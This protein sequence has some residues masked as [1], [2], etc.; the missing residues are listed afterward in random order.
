M[1]ASGSDSKKSFSDGKQ[2]TEESGWPPENRYF[3]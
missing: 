3:V 1:Y 2:K